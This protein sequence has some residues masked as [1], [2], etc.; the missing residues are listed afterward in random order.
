MTLRPFRLPSDLKALAEIIPPAFQYP[1]NDAWSMQPEEAESFVETL[2]GFRRIWPLLLV[3]GMLSP[4]LRDAFRGFV[5]E[6]D[7]RLVGSANVL[8]QGATDRWYIANVAV[9]PEYRRRGIARRLVEACMDL[10][11]ERGAKTLLLDVVAGNVPAVSLYERLGFEHFSGQTDMTLDGGRAVPQVALPDSIRLERGS[12]FNWRPHYALAQRITPPH[13]REY[14]PVEEASFRRPAI[15][16]ALIPAIRLATGMANYGMTMWDGGGRV[17]ATGLIAARTRPGG[18]N[19]LSLMLDPAVGDLG[20]ALI[21]VAVGEVRRLSPGQRI[22]L[23]VP[24][25]QDGLFAAA[26]EAGFTRR[27]DEHSMGM[28]VQAG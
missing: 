15:L 3:A 24:H 20:P 18:V 6:E 5:W 2:N 7:G 19:H 9:L 13:V 14:A 10:A 11:K 4:E 1:E 22:D 26:L 25:W 17:V 8:R 16:R 27:L 21:A 12:L 23:S 28:H